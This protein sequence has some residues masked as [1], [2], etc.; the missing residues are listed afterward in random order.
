MVRTVVP[1]EYP[2]Q[3]NLEMKG[4]V[5]LWGEEVVLGILDMEI[6]EGFTV[7]ELLQALE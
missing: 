4:C 5:Y 2:R 7:F 3:S 1:G 6:S